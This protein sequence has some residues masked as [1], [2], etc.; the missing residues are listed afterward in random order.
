LARKL[1]TLHET[2]SL[3]KNT[4]VL[5]AR[6]MDA[7]TPPFTHRRSSVASITMTAK[8]NSTYSMEEAET[9]DVGKQ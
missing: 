1:E 8:P 7:M 9:L 4:A 3:L 6:L 5:F 2:R